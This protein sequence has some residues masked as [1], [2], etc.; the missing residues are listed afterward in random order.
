MT[1]AQRFIAGFQGEKRNKSRHEAT[2]GFAPHSTPS[3]N[4]A[5]TVLAT[6]RAGARPDP[7]PW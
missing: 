3:V 6:F 2:A 1:I 7:M 4:R 5:P